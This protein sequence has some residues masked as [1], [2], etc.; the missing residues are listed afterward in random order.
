MEK[1]LAERER[2][3]GNKISKEGREK[4]GMKGNAKTVSRNASSRV[5]DKS[6]E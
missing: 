3:G 4:P 1:K 2:E 6:W 5:V